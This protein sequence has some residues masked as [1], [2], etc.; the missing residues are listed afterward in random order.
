MSPV[1]VDI[2]CAARILLYLE[3]WQ[4]ISPVPYLLGIILHTTERSVTSLV[5]KFLNLDSLEAVPPQY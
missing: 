5:L 3:P 2:H 1:L 4:S